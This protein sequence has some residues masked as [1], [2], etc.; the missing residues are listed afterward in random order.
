[1]CDEDAG[2]EG[3]DGSSITRVAPHHRVSMAHLLVSASRRQTTSTTGGVRPVVGRLGLGN[4]FEC[5]L[6]Y[7]ISTLA[8][9]PFRTLNL[10]LI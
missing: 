2:R 1:V 4:P 5:L 6:E 9:S 7:I 8:H 3:G 10:D